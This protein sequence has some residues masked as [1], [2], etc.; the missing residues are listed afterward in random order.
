MELLGNST[1]WQ[2]ALHYLAG[3]FPKFPL[4]KYLVRIGDPNTILFHLDRRQS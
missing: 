3:S 4:G 2:T 1:V